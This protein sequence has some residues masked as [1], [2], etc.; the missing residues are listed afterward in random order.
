LDI[1]L[2]ANDG[3]PLGV[4]PPDIY[5]RGLGGAELS[6]VSLMQTFA[7]RGHICRVFNNP[8]APGVYDN[9][10]YLPLNEFNDRGKRDAL[11]IFRS[12]N[13]TRVRPQNLAPQAKVWWS[14]DQQTSGNYRELAGW[15]DFCVTISP[16][17][18]AFHIGNYGIDPKKIGHLDLG[19]RLQDYQEGV[20]RIKNRLIFCSI[21][22]R[23]L[24]VLHAVW[25]L[26]K[27]KVVD[28]S[29]VITSDYRLWGTPDAGNQTH[30]LEWAG[31][32]DVQFLGRVPRLDLCRLQQEAELQSYPCT[33][34]ELFCISVAECATAGATPVTSTFAAIQT[35]NEWG[36]Q[37]PGDP[38][39]PSF[40]ETFVER[41]ASLLGKERAYMETQRA[42]MIPAA[43]QRFDWNNIAAKWEYLFEHK[44]LEP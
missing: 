13:P 11:I 40:V 30:R 22:E 36:V 42:T 3:S 15:V 5:G 23:G 19:V 20:Q 41:I 10:Q 38:T 26:L 24:R 16:Y 32:P 8:K 39:T 34:E 12:P 25:P 28:A 29:L 44:R 6:M 1:D 18:T 9:V 33:Y 31:E 27:R 4:I 14:C 21:P 7:A 17:H 35:T 37:I 2:V 43:R